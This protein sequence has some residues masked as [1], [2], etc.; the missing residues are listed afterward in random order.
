MNVSGIK[1]VTW[2]LSLFLS[3]SPPSLFTRLC[4]LLSS[5]LCSFSLLVYIF[6][7]L[8]SLP[9]VLSSLFSPLVLLSLSSLR[10]SVLPLVSCRPSALS[11]PLLSFPL[12]SSLSPFSPSPLL[13]SPLSCS[14]F[15]FPFLLLSSLFFIHFSPSHPPSASSCSSLLRLLLLFI[16]VS[17][18]LPLS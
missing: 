2:R 18:S 4:L 14:L 6:L 17:P 1:D 11:F 8:S 15:S 7:L 9:L 16:L 10:S 5:S 12:P 3:P 13:I